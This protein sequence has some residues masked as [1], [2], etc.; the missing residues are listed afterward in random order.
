MKIAIPI[1]LMLLIFS[2]SQSQQSTGQSPPPPPAKVQTPGTPAPVEKAT[3]DDQAM[4]YSKEFKD[5]PVVFKVNMEESGKGKISIFSDTNNKRSFSME[6]DVEG[7]VRD[8]FLLDL[9]KDTFSELY[10]VMG[11]EN[12]PEIM[13]FSSY[14]DRSAGEILIKENT[15]AASKKS[16]V[17]AKDGKLLRVFDD[18]TA[19]NYELTKGET[20]F[21]LTSKQE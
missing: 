17:V 9:D 8:A 2:C 5:D 14:Q 10:L 15:T 20:S 4:P 13:G 16:Q 19:W 11:N 7:N 21:I 6:F 3:V 18:N 1:G 12:S